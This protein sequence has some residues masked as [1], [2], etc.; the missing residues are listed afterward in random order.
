MRQLIHRSQLA[1][2]RVVVVGAGRSGI[3]A[4]RLA[5][6]LGAATRLVDSNPQA[7]DKDTE[8]LLS[9]LRVDVE[10]GEHRAEQ[11]RTADLIILS[12][13]VPKA[14]LGH[15]LPPPG[16]VPVLSELEVASWFVSEPIIAVTGTNGKTTTASLI[17]H[18]LTQTGRSAFL[19]G[20]IGTPLSEY[21]ASGEEKK[22]LVLEVSSF[23]LQNTDS[24]RP[25]VGLL[26]N[27]SP[28]HLD[29]HQS[30]EEYFECKLRLFRRQTEEDLAILPLELKETL[31]RHRS[32]SSRRVYFT[33]RG[34]FESSRLPGP[35]NRA[36]MEA[37]SLACK[38]FGVSEEEAD[39][40]FAS[41]EPYPHRLQPFEEKDGVLFV[42]DSKGTT[43]TSL[44]AALKSFDRP[45]LLLAGGRFK[46][47]DPE[48][49]SGLVGRKVRR[50]GLFGESRDLLYA[51]WSGS[52][53]AFREE[54]MER[55]AQ[56]MAQL[57]EKGDVVLLSPAGS[58]FDAYQ[59]YKERGLAFQKVVSEL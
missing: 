52:T 11:F 16:S 13:G 51:A 33:D 28:N 6:E 21:V 41:F 14:A 55:A 18:L 46:G 54:S 4:A 31:E 15:V 43:L 44:E 8:R 32:W 27:F 3:A 9:G 56:R 29:Y 47:G 58:S 2:H 53:E 37:A 24:F 5:V 25:K 26:L 30:L 17:H 23:Q 59:G 34:R 50:A 57:A 7:L 20:N 38:P 22:I 39:R 49:L 42:D 19:G 40:A 12:P 10:L 45:I 48:E 36:N 1:G 35:H